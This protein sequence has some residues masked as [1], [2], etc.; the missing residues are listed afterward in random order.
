MNENEPDEDYFELD[1]LAAERTDKHIVG[2]DL[3]PDGKVAFG[4][5]AL[6]KSEAHT[7]VAAT[8]GLY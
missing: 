2:K 4:I 8:G 7:C 6:F 5:F 1:H 3:M